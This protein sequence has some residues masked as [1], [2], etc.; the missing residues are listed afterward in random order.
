MGT[1]RRR[2][3][4]RRQAA[5]HTGHH[6]PVGTCHL[7]HGTAC[8]AYH[9]PGCHTPCP[10]AYAAAPATPARGRAGPCAGWKP[11]YPRVTGSEA[12]YCFWCY[13]SAHT[14]RPV[15]WLLPRRHGLCLRF[16][17]NTQR[18]L[19]LVLPRDGTA[20]LEQ[21]DFLVELL[22]KLTFFTLWD[23]PPSQGLARSPAGADPGGGLPAGGPPPAEPAESPAASPEP[24]PMGG[25]AGP[26]VLSP[27]EAPGAAD[28][29]EDSQVPID[30]VSDTPDS[31]ASA[32]ASADSDH[33]SDVAI[34]EPV[35]QAAAVVPSSVIYLLPLTSLRTCSMTRTL[36]W[37]LSSS[38]SRP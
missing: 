36:Q 24:E 31:T 25:G 30:L 19:R 20:P 35:D 18:V 27:D 37:A 13:T 16:R 15:A 11:V 3:S 38:R 2:L 5:R 26:A 34:V 7:G 9:V 28:L 4:I 14:C 10:S 23:R 6:P 17:R 21:D 8:A 22:P 1:L 32:S 33:S 12:L 29:A